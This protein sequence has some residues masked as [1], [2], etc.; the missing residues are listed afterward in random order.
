MQSEDALMLMS[1][2][3]QPAGSMHAL[4][5]ESIHNLLSSLFQQTR[6]VNEVCMSL[7]S[8]VSISFV[9]SVTNKVLLVPCAGSNSKAECIMSLCTR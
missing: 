6:L 5:H 3:V 2:M 8:Y 1:V 4:Q 7:V 9:N